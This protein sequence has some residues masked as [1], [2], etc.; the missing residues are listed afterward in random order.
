MRDDDVHV[1]EVIEVSKLVPLPQT[2]DCVGRQS[3]AVPPRQF[4]QRLRARRAFEMNVQL[5]FG[6]G[7][8][9]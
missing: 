9:E 8:N 7:A 1:D 2:L 5:H 6:H 3:H 4:E